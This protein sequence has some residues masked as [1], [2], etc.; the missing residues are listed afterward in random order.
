MTPDV[1]DPRRYAQGIPHADFEW[2]R[3]HEP[4]SWQPEHEV[5]DWPAGPGFWCVTRYSDVV[6]VLKSPREFSSRLG[7]TQIRD[8]DVSDLPFIRRM[9]LNLD[10]P[11][12][13]KLRRIVSR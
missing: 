7:A 1:F 11:E 3:T 6:H 9:M 8:P 4:V 13:G 2:L 5:G 10:P 12:H